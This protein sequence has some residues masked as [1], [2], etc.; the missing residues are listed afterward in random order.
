MNRIDAIMTRQRNYAALMD[1]IGWESDKLSD[2]GHLCLEDVPWLLAELEKYRNA[3]GHERDAYCDP[4][5]NGVRLAKP[6]L[7]FVLD[8]HALS[9]PALLVKSCKRIAQC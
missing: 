5:T 9:H 4:R 6:S 2:I 7:Q 8:Q 1:S 3:Q